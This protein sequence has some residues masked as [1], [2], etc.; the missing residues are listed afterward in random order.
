M[1][2]SKN[3]KLKFTPS[4]L[5]TLA[6]NVTDYTCTATYLTELEEVDSSK[7]YVIGGYVDLVINKVLHT[8]YG[9]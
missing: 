5:D 6:W 8:L 4:S 1:L 3:S 7:V 9:S 2:F